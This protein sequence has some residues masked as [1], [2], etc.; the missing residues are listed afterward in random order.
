MNRRRRHAVDEC[1][2]N[3]CNFDDQTLNVFSRWSSDGCCLASALCEENA[4]WAV[5]RFENRSLGTNTYTGLAY[6]EA[7]W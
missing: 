2:C 4:A 6:E 1:Y 3:G 7:G 5:D